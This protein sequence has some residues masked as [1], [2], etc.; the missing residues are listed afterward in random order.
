MKEFYKYRFY[1]IAC[2]AISICLF[3][4]FS[5]LN[6]NERN[7]FSNFNRLTIPDKDLERIKSPAP[8][9]LSFNKFYHLDSVQWRDV[10]GKQVINIPT[11]YYNI[12][13]VDY[14]DIT[15]KNYMMI[16]PYH[17]P[18]DENQDSIIHVMEVLAGYSFM[19][20]QIEQAPRKVTI[21][22]YLD[23][24]LPHAFCEKVYK[25]LLQSIFDHKLYVRTSSPKSIIKAIS[26]N[27]VGKITH[28]HLYNGE[29]LIFR[30]FNEGHHASTTYGKLFRA[31]IDEDSKELLIGSYNDR[32]SINALKN[33]KLRA[34]ILAN[35]HI[36]EINRELK[37]EKIELLNSVGY[38]DEL[39]ESI[40]TAYPDLINWT[41]VF[42]ILMFIGFIISLYI[43]HD[44]KNLYLREQNKLNEMQIN[45]NDTSNNSST[46]KSLA[47]TNDKNEDN[48]KELRNNNDIQWAVEKQNSI[49]TRPQVPI[50]IQI[51]SESE[52]Q[53]SGMCDT[54]QKVRPKNSDMEVPCT[55]NEAR[56]EQ[57]KS[58]QIKKE[59]CLKGRRE[60]ELEE[61][62]I[63]NDLRL[64]SQGI[65]LGN[66]ELVVEMINKLKVAT[67]NQIVDAELLEAIYAAEKEYDRK[68]NEGISDVFE[69]S[70][71]DY[72][73]ATQIE[74]RKNW[75]Y[76]V[77]KFPIKGTLV[78][79]Y[80][81]RKIARRGYMEK[82]LQTYLAKELSSSKLLILG[83]C[84]I[85]PADNY[86]AYEPDIA[87]IDIEHPSIRIDIEIDEPYAAITNIPIHYIGSGDDFRDMNLNNLGWIVV[88][89]TEYQVKTDMYGC[90]SFIAQLIHSIN[91]SKS[92]PKALLTQE[93]P[94][95]QKRWTEIEAKVM[96][97]EKLRQRYLSHEFGTSDIEKIEI[98][99]IKQTEKEKY[100]AKLVPPL[101]IEMDK[102]KNKNESVTFRRDDN[103][104]FLPYEHIYLYNGQ[105][106]FTAVSNI[107][108]CFFKPFDSDY[109]SEYKAKQYHVPQGQ[110]LEEWDAKGACSRD[111]GTFMHQQIENYYEGGVYQQVYSFIYE[112][113][114]VQKNEQIS[115]QCEYSQFME[116]LKNHKFS[117]FRTE[118]TI[119]DED[120]KIAGTVDMIHRHGNIF[121]IYD[122]KR[123]HRIVNLNGE[124]III[125]NYGEKGLGDLNKID[126]T[127]YW[128]YCIQQNIYR[129]ILEKN[130]DV[131]VGKMYLIVF[132]KDTNSYNK[133]DVPYMDEVIVHIVSACANRKVMERLLTLRGE[134][135]S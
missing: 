77:A 92:F 19:L 2:L 120:L 116:F 40:K 34:T 104:Q 111:V 65:K 102:W 56:Y 64:L 117:P 132:C 21:F 36:E 59:T 63:K 30:D 68:Y 101:A 58:N 22:D 93:Y 20:Y 57:D 49:N 110:I 11:I 89:F 27:R 16:C 133:L 26:L 33:Y 103:I 78:F 84:A 54:I 17:F 127:P 3:L 97:S 76:V 121:D 119:Y 134:N 70:Y 39:S 47:T 5:I 123:S 73:G 18:L 8:L 86:R 83:D 62:T 37:T 105:E 79:P 48:K 106:Q 29:T 55:E 85:L 24:G 71:V 72:A 9:T 109:W 115:L 107:I 130:Y 90:T 1:A 12:E 4:I 131:R 13:G 50:A 135:L 7:R 46:H 35:K 88:R 43:A 25:P 14:S 74:Q 126:D 82:A 87:I 53:W 94:K 45:S 122:W 100:C 118:W 41:L 23:H 10:N 69:I 52:N 124:P 42:C 44:K 95:K 113:K 81:R 112:G 6:Y 99:D 75:D 31:S 129:Y 51:V 61:H 32:L 38:D 108:S 60:K 128:H 66:I 91:P 114:Y 96:A 80:R 15:A 28:V 98:T 67:K 125:N